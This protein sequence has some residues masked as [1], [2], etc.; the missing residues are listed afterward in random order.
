MGA[1][2]KK[3]LVVVGGLLIVGIGMVVVWR[4]SATTI[5]SRGYDEFQTPPNAVSNEDWNLP[6]GF[7]VK[8]SGS[9]S[10]P[11]SARVSFNRGAAVHGFSADTVIERLDSVRVPGATRVQVIGRRLVSAEP[12]AVSFEDGT[13]EHYDISVKESSKLRSS[14]RMD[15]FTNNEVAYHLDVN[16]EYTCTANGQPAKVFDSTEVGWEPTRL[17]ARGTWS[18]TGREVRIVPRTD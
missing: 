14:G 12:L 8:K 4:T 9:K 2:Q 10:M 1:V 6:G 5:I 11:L 15:F 3:K 18:V 17:S 7:F 13:T 16:R